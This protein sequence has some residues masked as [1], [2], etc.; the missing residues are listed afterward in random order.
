MEK[1]KAGG[2]GVEARLANS[3]K[4]LAHS[5]CQEVRQLHPHTVSMRSTCAMIAR[6]IHIKYSEEICG[7]SGYCSNAV[8]HTLDDSN[9]LNLKLLQKT[10]QNKTCQRITHTKDYKTKYVKGMA[11]RVSRTMCPANVAGTC[12]IAI[13]RFEHPELAQA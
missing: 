5:N 11:P 7:Q 12:S 3:V 1:S 4:L 10:L 9:L 13:S 6:R 2:S 8:A